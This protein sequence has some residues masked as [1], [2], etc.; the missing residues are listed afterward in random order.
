MKQRAS[1]KRLQSKDIIEVTIHCIVNNVVS[2]FEARS[3]KRSFEGR[4][5]DRELLTKRK[6]KKLCETRDSTSRIFSTRLKKFSPSACSLAGVDTRFAYI[7]PHTDKCLFTRSFES[8]AR[9]LFVP[10]FL[11]TELSVAGFNSAS[12]DRIS[13]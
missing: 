9:P 4:V 12:S 13:V 10:P 1:L 8:F 11:A 7:S 6:A 2:K 5:V 3:S